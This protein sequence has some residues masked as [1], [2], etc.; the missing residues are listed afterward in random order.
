MNVLYR[1]DFKLIMKLA[2]TPI[3]LSSNKVY[4]CLSHDVD[5]VNLINN[6]NNNNNNSN[7]NTNN[8]KQF[9]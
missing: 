1:I 7:N 6:T 9:L 2:G 5:V 3:Y 8:N 4:Y